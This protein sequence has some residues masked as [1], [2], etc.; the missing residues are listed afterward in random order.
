VAPEEASPN[1][2]MTGIA[3]NARQWAHPLRKGWTAAE[4]IDLTETVLFSSSNRIKSGTFKGQLRLSDLI[5]KFRITVNAIDAK[6]SIGYKKATFQS[7]KSLYVTFDLPS[8]MTASDKMKVNL[9]IGNLNPFSLNVKFVTD[10]S[11]NKGPIQYTFP[12]GTFTVR[13]R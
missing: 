10:S 7:N 11:T 9:Q 1:D 13:S 6:G 5:T 12:L 8:T 2:F 3:A 4:R